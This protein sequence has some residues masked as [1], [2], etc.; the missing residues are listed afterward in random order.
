MCEQIFK[1]VSLNFLGV[2]V[3]ENLN[4]TA[5]ANRRF[6][7]AMRALWYIKK[8][9][10]QN[11]NQYKLNAYR[12]YVVTIISYAIEVRHPSKED[13]LENKEDLLLLLE[14]LQNLQKG[15][16]YRIRRQQ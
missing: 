12:G 2:V 6:S 5:N 15:D 7:K 16:T 4:W 9:T 14:N 8:Y 1:P 13:L 10:K 3:T 11:V